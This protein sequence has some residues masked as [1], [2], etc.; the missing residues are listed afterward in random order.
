MTPKAKAEALL[1]RL[2]KGKEVHDVFVSSMRTQLLVSGQPIEHWEGIFKIVVPSDN[3]TPQLCKEL[4]MKLLELSQE[5]AF[6]HAAAISWAQF[7]KRGSDAGYHE[8]FY[9]IV[10]EYRDEGKKLPAAQTLET[11]A[12]IENMDTESAQVLAE[13][14][15]KY[16]KNILDHLST[17]RKII[18]NASLNISVEMKAE[19]NSAFIDRLNTQRSN[20]Q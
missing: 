6:Y 15:T 2:I 12:K 11:L 14:T 8:R 19:A 20:G 13:I 7:I 1:K 18:E 5:A 16:W 3:L 17:C 4:D 10:Q 9:A